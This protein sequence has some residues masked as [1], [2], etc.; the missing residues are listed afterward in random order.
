MDKFL[1]NP[2]PIFRTIQFVSHTTWYR[3]DLSTFDLLTFFQPWFCLTSQTYLT[4]SFE[5][6]LSLVRFS[7]SSGTTASSGFI[8]IHP[9]SATSCFTD[10]RKSVQLCFG[11]PFLFSG[12]S[13]KTKSKIK[14]QCWFQA[15]KGYTSF[16]IRRNLLNI[17]RRQNI[18]NAFKIL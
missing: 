17:M 12:V 6:L 14:L 4:L 9:G 11:V 18:F 10:S 7:H 8:H 5:H 3:S 16:I 13:L 1:W 2:H 15:H